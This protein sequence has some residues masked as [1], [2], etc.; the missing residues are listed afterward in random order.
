MPTMNAVKAISDLLSAKAERSSP[1]SEVT[2]DTTLVDDSPSTLA[3]SQL[4]TTPLPQRSLKR[5]FDKM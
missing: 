3:L 2:G 1:S 4:P 5:T